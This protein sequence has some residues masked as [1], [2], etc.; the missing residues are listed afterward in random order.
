MELLETSACKEGVLVGVEEG[1]PK[2]RNP[3]HRKRTCHEQEPSGKKEQ[4]YTV[5]L[6][7]RAL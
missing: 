5:R 7:G 4:C 3:G 2:E 1:T 6:F